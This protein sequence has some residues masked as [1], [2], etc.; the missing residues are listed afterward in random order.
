MNG[1][2]TGPGAPAIGLWPEPAPKW[3]VWAA[4][5]LWLAWGAFLIWMLILRMAQ[6]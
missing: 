3:G 1:T 4:A 5:A 6:D 2:D